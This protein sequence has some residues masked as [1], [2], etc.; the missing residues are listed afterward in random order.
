MGIIQ[1]LTRS[2]GTY[3]T[4]ARNQHNAAHIGYQPTKGTLDR[5]NPPRGGSGVPRQ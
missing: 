5:S 1:K 3:I 2:I 4:E